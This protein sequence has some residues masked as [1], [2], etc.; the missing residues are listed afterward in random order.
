MAAAGTDLKRP[1]TVEAILDDWRDEMKHTIAAFTRELKL[2]VQAIKSDVQA[3]KSDVQSL[4]S[5][6]EDLKSDVEDLKS[7]VQ[8]IKSDVQAI[9]SD[10]QSLNT[11]VTRLLATNAA[12]NAASVSGHVVVTPEA[13][14][15][16]V[17][18]SQST[19]TWV[20]H[21]NRLFAVG[22]VHCGLY[23]RTVA[24]L[25]LVFVS[26]PKAVVDR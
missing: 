15:A 4:K 8:A 10:V 24:P 13:Q 22:C 20:H 21:E 7:D 6:V 25:G 26:L 12:L 18:G 1:R 14:N 11:K 2:D 5:D 9:K 17:E 16:V 3:V 23:Y 19:W